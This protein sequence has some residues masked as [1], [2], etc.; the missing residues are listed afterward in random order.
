ME[1][2]GPSPQVRG[3]RGP[4]PEK[5]AS[6]EDHLEVSWADFCFIR[7]PAGAVTGII[8][9]GG[10]PEPIGQSRARRGHSQ[11]SY[12]K[13]KWGVGGDSD[14]QVS[15]PER[16]GGLSEQTWLPASNKAREAGQLRTPAWGY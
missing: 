6:S 16:L 5:R 14:I 8:R 9:R 10:P 15:G 12:V 3:S 13:L 4:R 1:P 2:G 11:R 7:G